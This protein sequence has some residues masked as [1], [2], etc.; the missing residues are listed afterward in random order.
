[1]T[2]GQ[3]VKS[4]RTVKVSGHHFSVFLADQGARLAPPRS[5]PTQTN[6]RLWPRLQRH[7]ISANGILELRTV[8]AWNYEMAAGHHRG[9]DSVQLLAKA[10][11]RPRPRRLG[12]C[13]ES[14]EVAEIIGMRMKV[15]GGESL[16]KA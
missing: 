12:R 6:L 5:V 14:L 1:M 4:F 15:N 2:A 9:L 11:R 3:W 16:T 7:W 10:D 13:Q 8:V